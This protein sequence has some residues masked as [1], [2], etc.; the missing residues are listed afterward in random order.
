MGEVSSAIEAIKSQLAA[1]GDACD[2]LTHRELVGLLSELT[3]VVWSIPAVEHRILNRLT[4]ETEPGAL[5]ESSWKKVLATALRISTNDAGGRLEQ[6]AKLGPRRAMTGE[7]LAPLWEATAAAQAAGLIGPEH[8]EIIATFHKELPSWVDVGTRE[9]ADT[10][11]AQLAAGVGPAELD[12]AA[13]QLLMM[14][15]QDGPE[16][17][18]KEQARKRGVTLGPQRRDGTCAVR[19][20][21]TAQARAVIEAVL[22]KLAAPG[23]SLP[24]EDEDPGVAGEP[25]APPTGPDLRTQ[26]QR[27]H[28]ALV[29]LGR[30]ALRS[31]KLGTH[32]GLPVTVI[33]ST[34]LQELEKGAGLAVTGGGTRL[35]M[36]DVIRMAARAHHY[37]YVYD[38][39]TS[40]SLYLGRTKRLA[41]AA[42]RIVLHARDRGCTK[43]GCTAPGYHAQVHHAVTD[44]KNDGHTNIDELTF[45][46]GPD[47]RLIEKTGWTTRKRPDGRTEWLPPPDLDRGQTR[48]NNYHH[49]DRYLLPEDDQGP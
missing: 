40:A 21:L 15:D 35:P 37:L 7:S 20:T 38:K 4:A 27:N 17:S 23:M 36:R 44:W 10:Q 8:V 31:G 29:A 49:P 25:S 1:L 6:T 3:A 46:C 48:T 14:I 24:E 19:G 39:H 47:N 32:N 12:A 33:V 43:P 16:P 13:G 11:L 18:E 5:G 2:E 9:V 28:D 26:A 34:T 41:S 22:A 45:A 42:Q 30:M